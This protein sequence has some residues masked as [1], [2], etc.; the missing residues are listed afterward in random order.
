MRGRGGVLLISRL[1]RNPLTVSNECKEG[2]CR[3]WAWIHKV[4]KPIPHVEQCKKSRK[5]DRRV[6]GINFFA[7]CLILGLS[8]GIERSSRVKL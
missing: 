6:P 8:M 3:C 2:I 1:V 4:M 7:Q 5:E